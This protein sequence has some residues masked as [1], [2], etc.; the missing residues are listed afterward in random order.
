MALG[1]HLPSFPFAEFLEFF[2]DLPIIRLVVNRLAQA[3][4]T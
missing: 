4:P 2:A 3:M 1:L